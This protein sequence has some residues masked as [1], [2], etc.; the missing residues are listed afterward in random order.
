[1]GSKLN[2]EKIQSSDDEEEK[3]GS[4]EF[5]LNVAGQRGTRDTSFIKKSKTAR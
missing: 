1:M 3:I 2:S 5:D 4:Q